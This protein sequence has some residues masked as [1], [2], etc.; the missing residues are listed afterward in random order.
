MMLSSP[1]AP[2]HAAE[3]ETSASRRKVLLI[4]IGVLLA[5]NLPGWAT[6]LVMKRLPGLRVT[7]YLVTTV[8]YVVLPFLAARRWPRAAR[9]EARWLPIKRVDYFLAFPLL[10]I[11]VGWACL[12]G[13]FLQWMGWW[14]KDMLPIGDAG[15]IAAAVSLFTVVVAGPIAEEVLH[16]GYVQDQLAKI[17][18][19][20]VAVVLQAALFAVLHVPFHAVW[21]LVAF[22]LG[23]IF[24]FW[25][26][27]KRC[28]VPLIIVHVLIN[29]LASIPPYLAVREM[30]RAAQEAAASP[31]G[32]EISR[33]A[34]GPPEAGIPAI[35]PYLDDGDENIRN[36]AL[37]VL[38]KDY[39]KA[40]SRQYAQVLKNGTDRQIEGILLVIEWSRCVELAPEV[41]RIVYERP[42]LPMQ[43]AALIT[44]KTLADTEGL[45]EIARDHPDERVRKTASMMLG[46]ETRESGR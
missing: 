43:I 1:D 23:L 2:N 34:Q 5:C 21:S 41:R 32:R 25:R 9:F 26:Q 8:A 4:L 15:P 36:C 24:G 40:G 14:S 22:G 30:N 35:V 13:W 12:G 11:A 42:D 18:R 20:Y 44:L 38:H 33:L 45:T 19:S 7:L 37:A 6:A 27:W 16:R 17:T 10:I 29:G 3:A 28:L 39:G 31:K 46:H